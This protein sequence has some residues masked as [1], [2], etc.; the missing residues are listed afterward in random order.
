MSSMISEEPVD[1]EQL[2][3]VG[4]RACGEESFDPRCCL[5]TDDHDRDAPRHGIGSKAPQH[6]VAVNI[7]QMY[8]EHDELRDVLTG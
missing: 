1:V 5:G 7:R 3:Q 8:V 4:D 2:R 6:L